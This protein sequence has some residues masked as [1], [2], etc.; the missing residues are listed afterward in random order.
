MTAKIK[1]VLAISALAVFVA[2]FLISPTAILRSF[3]EVG[4]TIVNKVFSA[5]PSCPTGDPACSVLRT[6]GA[7]L[8]GIGADPAGKSSK[9]YI[10]TAGTGAG[11][12]GLRVVDSADAN[13]L[14]IAGD[15]KLKIYKAAG[16]EFSDGT[17]Q[18]TAASGSGVWSRSGAYVIL[19]TTTD[20]VGIG[21]STP[22]SKL[23]V[24]NNTDDLM[25]LTRTGATYPT[26][27]KQGTDGVLVINNTNTDTLTIKNG[28]IGIATTTPAYPL[29]VVGTI[30]GSSVVSLNGYSIENSNYVFGSGAYNFFKPYM[31]SPSASTELSTAKSLYLN[32]DADNNDTTSTFIVGTNANGSSATALMTLTEGGNLSLGTTNTDYNLQIKGSTNSD[33]VS[34][35]TAGTARYSRFLFGDSGSAG[36]FGGLV[37]FSNSHSGSPSL[38]G[39]Y[40]TSSTP[41]VISNSGTFPTLNPQLYVAS[42]GNVGIATSTPGSPL[43]VAGV[44]YSSTG[45]YKFPDGTTQTTAATSGG[46]GS[47]WTT[48]GTYVILATST[49]TVGIGIATPSN[50][51]ELGLDKTLRLAGSLA[52][53]DTYG[54]SMGGYGYFGIDSPGVGNGRFVVKNSGN[55]GIGTSTPS[56]K[57]DVNGNILIGDRTAA[58]DGYINIGGSGTGSVQI[59]RTGTGA[60]DSSMVF[61]TTYTT[62]QERMRISG[63]GNVGIGTTTPAY[64]FVVVNS[65]ITSFQVTS[66]TVTVGGGTG[67][68]NVGT[69]DPPYTINGGQYATYLSGMTGQK[70]ETTGE[71]NASCHP[72]LREGSQLCF[73]IIDFSKAEKGSD[74]WL[75]AKTTNLKNNL[76]KMTVLLTPSFDGKVWYEKDAKNNTLKIFAS[77]VI[78][79]GSLVDSYSVSYRLTAP[80]FD[81]AKWQ[82]IRNDAGVDGFIIND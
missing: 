74:L 44:V 18:T 22:A 16:L 23:D 35:D 64:P 51:L 54:L 58:T 13:V 80:R 71:I 25:H 39:I 10:K 49:N 15:G 82:N 69:I 36:A 47:G 14:T 61:S 4:H 53:N 72:E 60:T 78:S 26:I 77:P 8:F 19:A 21:T 9:L 56:A 59:S 12:Y 75:F 7:G 43:T 81:S 32:M 62:L 34:F 68:L 6:D 55:V 31:S 46:G 48:S 11:D 65:G 37:R 28:S 17:I 3:S 27:F 38:L 45:G 79:D 76:S 66:S 42:T 20:S 41:I 63:Q 2:A 5:G 24:V 40:N 70:E 50:A 30:K 1:V 67:K 29:H 57:L 33:I 73:A 52:S